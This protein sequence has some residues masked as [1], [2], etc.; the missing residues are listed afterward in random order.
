M[1]GGEM[2]LR[3]LLTQCFT[4]SYLTDRS[5]SSSK[6]KLEGPGNE[7]SATSKPIKKEAAGTNETLLGRISSSVSEGITNRPVTWERHQILILP[8]GI[9]KNKLL[10]LTRNQGHHRKH[11][12]YS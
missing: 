12:E 1:I 8:P 2:Y 6:R 3:E 9:A 4:F 11:R 5:S 7:I 10:F